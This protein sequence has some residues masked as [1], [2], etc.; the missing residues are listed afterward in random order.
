LVR[1]RAKLVAMRSSLKAQ[2]YAVLAKQGVHIP[3]SD[4]FGLGGRDLPA[5]APLDGPFRGRVD[6]LCRLIGAV[7]F[8]LDAVAGPIRARLAGN[9]GYRG[10]SLARAAA[11]LDILGGGRVEGSFPKLGVTA[12]AVLRDALSG[13]AQE[14]PVSR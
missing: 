2:V 10:G 7:E 3:V 9:S 14:I 11:S 6:A 12:R 5:K 13:F 4:L 1:H 8:E